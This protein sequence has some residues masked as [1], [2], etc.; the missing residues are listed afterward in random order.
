MAS[1]VGLRLWREPGSAGK[2]TAL[3]RGLRSDPL[4]W[5]RIRT[6]LERF[7]CAAMLRMQTLVCAPGRCVVNSASTSLGLH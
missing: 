1:V 4:I 2:R 6:E 3:R 7:T 5:S